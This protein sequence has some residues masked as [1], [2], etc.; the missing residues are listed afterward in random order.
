MTAMTTRTRRRSARSGLAVGLVALVLPAS[1]AAIDP[2][3]NYDPGGPAGK[4]Y[5]IPLVEGR[6]E[7]AGTTNQRAAADT[8]F[9]A[10]ITP[11]GGGGRGGTP[12]GGA[13]GGNRSGEQ[14]T[15]SAGLRQARRRG[16][17]GSEARSRFSDAENPGGT[18]GWTLAIA[19]AVLLSG[20]LIGLLLRKP[21]RPGV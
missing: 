21:A 15:R 14:G 20:L 6:A 18:A 13:G 12:G 8:P 5:A 3:V 2:G 17:S 7:G 1:A 11:P 16:E 19:L 4:E 9:G 10:G